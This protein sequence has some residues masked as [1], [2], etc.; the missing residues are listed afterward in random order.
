MGD[1]CAARTRFR[2]IKHAETHTVRCQKDA[3]HDGMHEFKK[4]ARTVYWSGDGEP[5]DN[6]RFRF[7]RWLE[8]KS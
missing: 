3:G 2:P 4:D 6:T 8:Q 1:T 7:G 5:L